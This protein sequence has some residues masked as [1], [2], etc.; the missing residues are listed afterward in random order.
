MAI[1]GGIPHF[2]TYPNGSMTPKTSRLENS[3]S[4]RLLQG[5]RDWKTP[6]GRGR[7]P[8]C[9][10]QQDT[11]WN[12][13]ALMSFDVMDSVD[14]AMGFHGSRLLQPEKLRRWTSHCGCLWH[15]MFK[16]WLLWL[17][18]RS[19]LPRF[20]ANAEAQKKAH[21]HTHLLGAVSF[22]WHWWGWR[23]KI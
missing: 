13:P 17:M 16:F 3:S 10:T 18:T 21:T 4:F 19:I 11:G 22:L 2:Q 1:I 8:W 6:E 20:L 5:W 14:V 15:V 12:D 9:L 23:V 7:V